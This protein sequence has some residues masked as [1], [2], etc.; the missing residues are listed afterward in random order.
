MTIGL[1]G[2]KCG[3]SRI[4]TDDGAV[5]PVSVL[6]FENV[7]VTQVKTPDSDGY[8]SIQVTKG[9][10][11]PSLVNKPLAGHFAKAGVEAG[12]GLYEFRTDGK[13][14][15]DLKVGDQINVDI[16][17]EGQMVDVTGTTKGRGFAGVVKRWGFKTR[18]HSSESLAH[19]NPGSIGQNQT[20]GR[21]K[22][23]KKMPGHYG[24]EKCTIQ[25]LEV[26]R[27]DVARGLLLV[28]G[29]VPGPQ[30]SV[31]IVKPAVKREGE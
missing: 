29:A 12:R 1:V 13:A 23:G 8:H 5:I 2:T 31:V 17:S 28:R 10:K 22:K 14:G 6:Q 18:D 3:M 30:G 15:A 25:N 16:F 21:V 11:R 24:N 27:V 20:P 4:F 9:S 26:V 7:R 19:R